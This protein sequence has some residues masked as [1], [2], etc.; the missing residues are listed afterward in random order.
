MCYLSKRRGTAVQRSGRWS[1]TR[2]L[3]G[4]FAALATIVTAHPAQP[5]RATQRSRSAAK[6]A[7]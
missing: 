1:G 7:Y 5:R 6:N 4:R 2:N 3:G